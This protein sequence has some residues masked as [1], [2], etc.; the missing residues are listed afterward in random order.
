VESIDTHL[1]LAARPALLRTPTRADYEDDLRLFPRNLAQVPDWFLT[2]LLAPTHASDIAPIKS[3]VRRAAQAACHDEIEA[4]AQAFAE[5]LDQSM[6]AAPPVLAFATRAVTYAKEHPHP[7][8]HTH[9]TDDITTH[10]LLGSLPSLVATSHPSMRSLSSALLPRLVDELRAELADGRNG[11]ELVTQSALTTAMLTAC[12]LLHGSAPETIERLCDQA[13]ADYDLPEN[14]EYFALTL[15]QMREHHAVLFHAWAV[16]AIIASSTP[17]DR[18]LAT[19]HAST[20]EL[21]D[22]LDA[23]YDNQVQVVMLAELAERA[24]QDQDIS[25]ATQ[26]INTSLYRM[27]HHGHMD[28]PHSWF[29]IIV[30]TQLISAALIGRLAHPP[31]HDDTR[32][33]VISTGLTDPSAAIVAV[34]S[35]NPIMRKAAISSGH[36]TLTR[37]LDLQINDP[38]PGVSAQATLVISQRAATVTGHYPT[39]H[40]PS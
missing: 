32:A 12:G 14:A 15:T 4:A 26:G 34:E 20:N 19:P 5:L 9:K 27:L 1:D 39:T 11:D 22:A 18:I 23:E 2:D 6:I 37:L 3:V 28:Q 30:R 35:S 33:V 40:R 29:P 7:P 25:A 24:S 16:S 36:L 38:D 17:A 13:F 8:A 10:S 31:V 21:A